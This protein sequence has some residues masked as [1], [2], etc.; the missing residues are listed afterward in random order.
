MMNQ[1][2]LDFK[3]RAATAADCPE[4]KRLI[5]AIMQEYGLQPAKGHAEE[6]LENLEQ[7]YFSR[8]GFFGV[9]TNEEGQLLG[10]FGLYPLSDTVAELR[11]MYLRPELRGKGLGRFM[12][13]NLLTLA[14]EK[15]FKKLEL[16]TAGVLKEAISLYTKY[17]F[18]PQCRE[19]I[20]C[21][22]DLAFELNL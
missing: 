9:I 6:D 10:T 22:C 13:E 1:Q 8:G 21:G 14:C 11:K 18:R 20:S 2:Y 16:E 5:I 3:L 12:L 17:G 4:A 15:G 7:S 19:K